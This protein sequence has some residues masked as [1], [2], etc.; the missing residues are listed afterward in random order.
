MLRCMAGV[1]LAQIGVLQKKTFNEKVLKMGSYFFKST[2]TCQD[3]VFTSRLNVNTS[4][5]GRNDFLHSSLLRG[6]ENRRNIFFYVHYKCVLFALTIPRQRIKL[7]RGGAK[8]TLSNHAWFARCFTRLKEEE[9]RKK[10]TTRNGIASQPLST[11]YPSQLALN[12][13]SEL[14]VRLS[15]TCSAL[16]VREETLLVFDWQSD[17]RSSG[18]DFEASTSIQELCFNTPEMWLRKR[19]QKPNSSWQAS[20]RKKKKRTK[21]KKNEREKIINKS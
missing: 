19:Q 8:R 14:W 9:K 15:T 16:R 1:A 7:G 17:Y 2:L 12:S 3:E 11:I 5:L 4:L 21:E 20:S 18:P 6:V 10:T 13:W